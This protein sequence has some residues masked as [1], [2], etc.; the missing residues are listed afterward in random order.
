M[1]LLFCSYR[2]VKEM[3]ELPYI[4]LRT[5]NCVTAHKQKYSECYKLVSSVPSVSTAEPSGPRRSSS[6]GRGGGVSPGRHH[7]GPGSSN[8]PGRAG[9]AGLGRAGSSHSSASGPADSGPSA[10]YGNTGDAFLVRRGALH[11]HRHCRQQ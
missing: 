4:E 10:A 7:G 5:E 9:Q 6:H 3:G 2:S 1:L 11:C 8:T